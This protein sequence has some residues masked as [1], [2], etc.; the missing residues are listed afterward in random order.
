MQDVPVWQRDLGCPRTLVFYWDQSC[1]N[2][3]E[4]DLDQAQEEDLDQDQEDEE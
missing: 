3:L 2:E 4:E 1:S